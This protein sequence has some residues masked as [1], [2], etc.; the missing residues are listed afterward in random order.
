MTDMYSFRVP[1]P[2]FIS[3]I[4]AVLKHNQRG[5]VSYL[6]GVR[7]VGGFWYYYPLALAVKTPLAMLVLLAL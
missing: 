6:L 2:E 3:G 5:H 1:A 4:E 7:N